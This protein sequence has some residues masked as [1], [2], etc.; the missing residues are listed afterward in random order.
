MV[1]VVDRFYIAVS[2]ALG[3]THYALVACDS[4]LMT[5]GLDFLVVVVFVFVVG[6]GGGGLLFFVC[7]LRLLNIHPSG[8]LTALFGCYAAGAT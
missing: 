5:L 6:G 3:Q 4:K 7:V 8:V 2:S 1:V